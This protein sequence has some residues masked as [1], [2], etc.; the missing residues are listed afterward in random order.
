MKA[1]DTNVLARYLLNDDP[2][3]SPIATSIMAEPNY[4]SDT[5][6]VEAAWLLSSRYGFDRAVLAGALADLLEATAAASAREA[7]GAPEADGAT[8]PDPSR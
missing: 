3:Q 2:V 8:G 7:A 5:V 6:L 4:V 1:V